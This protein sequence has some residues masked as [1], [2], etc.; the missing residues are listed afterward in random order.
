MTVQVSGELTLTD[1]DFRITHR[2]VEIGV[3]CFAWGGGIPAIAMV[4]RM[5]NGKYEATSVLFEFSDSPYTPAELTAAAGGVVQWIKTALMPRIN[6]ALAA[7]FPPEAVNPEGGSIEDIDAQLGAVLRWAP[8]A[9]GTLQVTAP[10]GFTLDIHNAV[11][12]TGDSN[13]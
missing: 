8:Q 13:G 11:I 1:K 4:E 9:D 5:P 10:P 12:G 3:K 7:R 2:G 6:A